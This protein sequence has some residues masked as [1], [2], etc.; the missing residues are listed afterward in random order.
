MEVGYLPF[1]AGEGHGVYA[2]DPVF[3]ARLRN[4][5]NTST[6]VREWERIFPTP[7]LGWDDLAEIRER[8]TLPVIAKGVLRADDAR[9]CIACGVD[10]VVVS[11][12]GGRQVDGCVPA[13]CQ[14]PEVAGAIGDAV[15]V[16]FDS[17]VRTGSDVLIALALGATAVLIG[18]PLVWALAVGG[19]TGVER[20]LRCLLADI[21]LTLANLGVSR[22][23]ELS[24]LIRVAA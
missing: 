5:D 24:S 17:G 14:L 21:E 2:S 10:G 1:S 8:T 4:G 11:N 15:P 3:R 22:I 16:F 9:R 23:D 13:I 18:R 19:Q 12:H 6:V 7:E 20:V